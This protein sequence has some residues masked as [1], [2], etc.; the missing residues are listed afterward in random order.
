MPKAALEPKV[1][2]PVEADRT[3]KPKRTGEDRDDDS[4]FEIEEI[5]V[6][7]TDILMTMRC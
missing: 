7:K 3:S 6:V 5:D 4:I 2:K 1:R